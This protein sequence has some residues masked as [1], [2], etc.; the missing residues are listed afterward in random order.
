MRRY[1]SPGRA[2]KTFDRLPDIPYR[3]FGPRLLDGGEQELVPFLGAG[4]SRPSPPPEGHPRPQ[5]DATLL[6]ELAGKLSIR[7]NDARLFLEIA[8]AVIGRLNADTGPE[9]PPHQSAYE[10]ILTST[11]PPS[12]AELAQALAERSAYDHF[13]QAK[14]RIRELTGRDDWDEEMLT[15]LLVAL[16]RLT[17]IGSPAP[18]LLDAS[19][20][21]AY[22]SPR[23]EFWNSLHLLFKDKREPTTTHALVASAAARYIE[24]NDDVTAAD[25]L[26]ITTNYDGLLEQSLDA[27]S[28]P[29]YVLT[30]PDREKFSIDL[31]FSDNARGYLDMSEA[32]FERMKRNVLTEGGAV[33]SATQFSGL[34]SKKRPLVML[35]KI[36]G[37]LD[38]NAT[39][40]KDGVVI[41]NEDYVT[42]LSV[43]GLVPGYVRTRL[44]GMGLLLLGYSFADWNVRSLYHSVTK[45]RPRTTPQA[46]NETFDYAVLLDPSPYEIG[47]FEHNDIDIFDTPLDDFCRHMRAAVS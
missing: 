1:G 25:Y 35:Y 20:Y 47:F 15:H 7:T 40:D 22:G 27:Q 5:V 14:R 3:L 30:V 33:R 26:V 9:G 10:R 6:Q 23:R 13:D 31:R 37:S 43:G 21:F 16:A 34:S 41:T 36:H 29:Y 12:T 2:T 17:A 18:P 45:F 39:P 24:K 28:V 44:G 8:V 19:S 42:F 4:A 38:V 46:A 11:I 32:Q